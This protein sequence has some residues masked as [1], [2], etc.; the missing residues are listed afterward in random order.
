M[1]EPRVG[2]NSAALGG[3]LRARYFVK[4]L[5]GGKRATT[6]LTT[7]PHS[8]PLDD[9]P[10]ENTGPKKVLQDSTQDNDGKAAQATIEDHQ[11]GDGDTHEGGDEGEL[12]ERNRAENQRKFQYEG[13][14]IGEG[15]NED[16]VRTKEN[17]G[18][19]R[20]S[21]TSNWSEMTQGDKG[22]EP[23]GSGLSFAEVSSPA[24]KYILA[25]SPHKDAASVRK[26]MI[27]HKWIPTK[28]KIKFWFSHFRSTNL[29]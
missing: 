29:C 20:T 3:A 19:T 16:Q 5:E 12:E 15:N 1:Q 7:L 26:R 25:C 27:T 24:V 21:S 13:D 2:A 9:Q 23:C 6:S 18:K 11:R 14:E 4:T 10:Q 17:D 22:G 28:T 8:A